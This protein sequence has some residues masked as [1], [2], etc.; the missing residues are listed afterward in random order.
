MP[1][2]RRPPAQTTRRLPVIVGDDRHAR[3]VQNPTDPRYHMSICGQ[4][5]PWPSTISLEPNK[6]VSTARPSTLVTNV[7]T[8][9]ACVTAI[10]QRRTLPFRIPAN[11]SDF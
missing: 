3:A 8:C 2:T 4:G 5:Y 6:A 10:E 7:V 9:R 1:P 11:S